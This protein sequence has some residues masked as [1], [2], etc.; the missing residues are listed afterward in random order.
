MEQDTLQ[1]A[2]STKQLYKEYKWYTQTFPQV[3]QQSYDEFFTPNFR[4]EL[5]GISK[6]I[7]CL[8]DK[9]SCFVTKV[10]IDYEYDMFFRLTDTAIEIILN[11]ALGPSKNKFNINKISELEA[12]VITTFNDF[13]YNNLKKC[14][15]PAPSNE[16]KRVNFDLINMTYIIQDKNDFNRKTG[17]V[18]VT[19]PLAL[20]HPESVESQGEKF[21]EMNFPNSSTSANLLMGKTNFSLYDLKNLESGD[22]VVFDDSDLEHVTLT[23]NG[24]I[25]PVNLSPN[26]DLLVTEESGGDDMG[27]PNKNIWDSIEVE[28]VAEFEGVK[29]SLG[30]LKD[31]EEGLV[32]DL[33][34]L[35]DNKVTLKVEDKS[36]ASGQLVIVNDRYGVKVDTIIAQEDTIVPSKPKKQAQTPVQNNNEEEN[37]EQDEEYLN[38][39]GGEEDEE[40]D[41]SEEDE[42]SEDESEEQAEEGEEEFDYTDFELEDENL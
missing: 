32:V 37:S 4:I 12:K 38:V 23:I 21:S 2:I 28:M 22:V 11:N 10:K 19:L 40:E 34:S 18:I 20:L 29:I 16:L 26:M 30:E 25:L 17:K 6:N 31:I 36:I 33:A 39:E 1:N 42:Y 5:I 14:L 8:I 41:Y 3:V 7:N 35:Y 15:S 9:E 27:E 13:M 24:E